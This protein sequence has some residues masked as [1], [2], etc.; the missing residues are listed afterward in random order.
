MK[1]FKFRELRSRRV[2]VRRAHLRMR[3]I[4]Y[5]EVA[6]KELADV[7]RR[8]QLNDWNARHVGRGIPDVR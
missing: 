2:A 1:F 8:K 7:R 6:E 3:L 4:E 5:D